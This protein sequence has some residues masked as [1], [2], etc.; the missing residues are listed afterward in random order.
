MPL[1]IVLILCV[2]QMASGGSVIEAYAS[3]V[4]TGTKLSPNASTVMV[5][6]CVVAA[7]VP[8]ALSVDKYGRRPLFIMSC[9]GTTAC[10]TFVVMMLSL[11]TSAPVVSWM[12]LVGISGA[13]FFINIGIMPLVSV[14]QCE[15]FPSD[16]RGL[17]NSAAVLAITSTSA[18]MLKVY[19]PIS[20]TFGKRTNFIVYAL[21]SFF[22]GLFC[23]LYV[24]E[25][26]GKTFQHIQLD[27]ETYAWSW[28]ERRRRHRQD[29]ERI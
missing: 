8:F 17:A 24:P 5:G 6:L 21:I 18:I 22:G 25:T 19:Q 2:L 1:I 26:K 9:V 16:T 29:Y 28:F 12:L 23:Y 7:C 14:I 3:S 20:D 13:V 11:D 4:L 27:F 10:H 15:Y